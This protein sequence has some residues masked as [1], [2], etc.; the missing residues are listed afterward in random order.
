[1]VPLDP[2]ELPALEQV[3]V[4]LA[5]QHPRAVC[6][7]EDAVGA[8][9]CHS[10]LLANRLVHNPAIPQPCGPVALPTPMGAE[11]CHSRS[12][13]PTQRALDRPRSDALPCSAGAAARHARACLKARP[14][15]A[16]QPPAQ[17]QADSLRVWPNAEAALCGPEGLPRRLAHRVGPV[18]GMNDR[19]PLPSTH[20]TQART[21]ST[22]PPAPS[23]SLWEK[24]RCTSLPSTAASKLFR[25]CLS[26]QSHSSYAS[27]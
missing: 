24:A 20:T 15:C 17:A 8:K 5:A 26:S 11:L 25:R 9:L 4:A 14:V 27:A 1:M 2:G 19:C 22:P 21:L 16:G 23:R 6:E 7:L 3:L 13:S 10:L 12:S 18:A